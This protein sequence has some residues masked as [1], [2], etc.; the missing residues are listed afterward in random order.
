L[1]RAWAAIVVDFLQGFI[2]A[3]GYVNVVG[4]DLADRLL[5]IPLLLLAICLNFADVD[6]VVSD[7]DRWWLLVPQALMRSM[8]ATVT[9]TTM[10]RAIALVAAENLAGGIGQLLEGPLTYL[11]VPEPVFWAS[12]LLQTL[13][14]IPLGVLTAY[15]YL[16]AVG[17]ES[18][19]SCSE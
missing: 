12:T 16:D 14:A 1:E 8:R 18:K 4:G 19:R 17:Y 13:I 3:V 7:D 11:H 9:G 5:G 6:A 15:V 2:W 10:I